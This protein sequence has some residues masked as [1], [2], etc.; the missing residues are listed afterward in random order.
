[1]AVKA[2]YNE[3]DP[4]AAEWLRNLI[5]KGLIA[6]GEVDERSIADVHADDLRG[7]AQCHFFAGIGGWS[8]A[9]RLA[10]WPDDRPVWTGSC[11]CQPFSASS[12]MEN[13]AKGQRDRRH[14]WPELFRLISKCNPP[15][16]FGEQVPDAINWGW[17]DKAA[18]D[19]EGQGYAA[20]AIVLRAD[21]V[22][23]LHQRRRLYWVAD[24]GR[25]GREGLEQNNGLSVSTSTPFAKH[26]NPFAGARDAMDGRYRDLLPGDGLSVAVER[27]AAK[28]Y[29]NAIIPQVA[30]EFIRA[31]M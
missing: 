16:I 8:Y 20:G 17:W 10:G 25:E 22:G 6:D 1:M 15:I 18:L 3:F 19:V 14:L 21:A 23:A 31:V 7:F 30:A 13:Y 27:C 11:P 12:L 4:Y 24:A 9:L 2:Y 29:G 5:S 28:G 26:G